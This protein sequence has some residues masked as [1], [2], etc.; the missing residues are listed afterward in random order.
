MS[1]TERI[2]SSL[3]PLY[4]PYPRPSVLY[5]VIDAVGRRLLEAENLLFEVMRAHWVD[6]ADQSAAE[7]RDLARL[8]A[9]YDLRPRDDEDVET[10]RTH[11]K[12]YVRAYLEGSATPRGV[13]HLAASTLA[14]SL[15]D[16]LEPLPSGPRYVIET[17]HPG[18][19]ATFKLFG[20]RSAEAHGSAPEPARV[21]GER[22][23]SG[24]IDPRDLRP[25]L[26]EID[27]QVIAHVNFA[28]LDP[29][30]TTVWD[31]TRVINDALADPAHPE[32][33]TVATHD[34]RTLQ[35]TSRAG[36]PAAE[37]Q[38]DSPIH[39]PADAARIDSAD[40]LLGVAPRH[41]AGADSRPA[42]VIGTRDHAPQGGIPFASLSEVRYLRLAIDGGAPF[43]VDCAGPDPAATPLDHVRDQINASAGRPVASHDGH[44]LTLT[45]PTTGAASRLELPPAPANDARDQLLGPDARPIARGSNAAPAQLVGRADLTTAV[46]LSTRNLL[47]LRIDDAEHEI[48]FTQVVAPGE[49]PRG[50]VVTDIVTA[51]NGA[52]GATVASTDG[53]RLILTSTRAGAA[54]DI[55]VLPP[56]DPAKDAADLVL[57][58]APRVQHGRP[59]QRARIDALATFNGSDTLD[60]RVQQR[61]WLSVDGAP[62]RVID[63]AGPEPARTTL[64]HVVDTINQSLGTTVAFFEADPITDVG[65]L[66]L[67]SPTEG[68]ASSVTLRAP[69]TSERRFFYTRGRVRED[70]ATALFGFAAGEVVGRLPQPAR[71]IGEV[72]LSRG[73]DLRVSHTLRLQV[74][75]RDFLDVRVARTDRPMVTLVS[76]V[77]EKINAALKS[78]RGIAEPVASDRAGRLEL[79]S[80]TEGPE[81]RISIGVST[82]SD[83]GGVLFGLA[84]GSSASG[85][86]GDQVR[87]V[88]MGDLARGL[89]LTTTHRLRVGIDDRGVVEIDLQ[90]AVPPGSPPILGPI[91]IAAAIDLALGGSY[92][93]QDGRHVILTSRTTGSAS[94]IRIETGAP[95]DA[96]AAV[97]GLTTSREYVGRDATSAALKGVIDLSPGVDLRERR[98]LSL[99][100][101][102]QAVNDIDCAGR[103]QG[104]TSPRDLLIRIND[105]INNQINETYRRTHREADKVSFVGAPGGMLLIQSPTSGVGSAVVLG[106]SSAADAAPRLLAAAPR[107]AIGAAGQPA[108]LSGEIRLNRPVDLGRRSVVRLRVDGGEIRDVDCS[109]ERP[110]RTFPDEAVGRI[111]AVYPGLATV[112]GQRHL[113]LTA[114]R[115]VEVLPLRSFTLFEFDPSATRAPDQPVHHGVS[116]SVVNDSVRDEPFTWDLASRNGVDRPRLTNRASGRWIEIEGV[117]PAG[118]TLHARQ[119]EDDILTA[120]IDGP[121]RLPRDVTDRLR[122]GWRDRPDLAPVPGVLTLPI[123][124]STWV[125]SD[126]YGD[127]FDEATF[128]RRRRR[129]RAPRQT[130]VPGH[131]AGGAE[132]HAPAI[133]DESWYVSREDDPA[134]LVH[135]TVYGSRGVVLQPQ[136][137]ATF[138]YSTH[139]AGRFELQLPAD[140]PRQLG[141]R[142]NVARY[143]ARDVSNEEVRRNRF[144]YEAATF[145][146]PRDPHALVNQLAARPGVVTGSLKLDRDA[147]DDAVPIAVLPFKLDQP[148]VGGDASHPARAY[149]SQPG[150]DGL[151]KLTAREPGDWGNLI[152]VAAPESTVPG[153]FDVTIIYAGQDVYEN[154]RPKVLAQL[155]LARAAGIQ[156]TV[157]RQ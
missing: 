60:L 87:F 57:G 82:A 26:L 43:E 81:G 89:D 47:R 77:V 6:F 71:L 80:P 44:F 52:F 96:T 41:Y 48:D 152:R 99:A 132:C 85:R 28:G 124:Q 101:D 53:Q 45:S 31:I 98:H 137:T 11:L 24:G 32:L 149:L 102:G 62:A 14:L 136:A 3:P 155:A 119:A 55:E 22:D 110:D 64:Q 112:D 58:V 115:R 134:D 140:L 86:N 141:G 125:Y 15:E 83:A 9:L 38:F 19:D 39:D 111:N 16:P 17:T 61:L 145:D 121:G 25:L 13:L 72:D 122:T 108:T 8:A 107:V 67:E 18:D 109:G 59:P 128:G 117:V 148:L 146:V 113:V 75:D 131:Y 91:Q 156:V 42:R 7:I 34:G 54:G 106:V 118:M 97:F 69:E 114:P 20:F 135:A 1:T 157:T 147:G 21:V 94:R 127:R 100:I 30:T 93:T 130:T 150:V 103:D 63:C 104:L 27:G 74:D 120:W 138:K 144:T 4:R 78:E 84:P 153:A 40:A 51:L 129:G 142:F 139:Q 95:N 143:T 90:R 56:S 76:D 154:A 73:A 79:I 5:T 50:V 36:G 10:F 46:D 116:W 23:L 12:S 65:R 49:D 126:C 133:Y 29:G 33:P 2:L 70:A 68:A 105:A 35:L 123:G 88:G 66:R 37:I 151:V 92:T